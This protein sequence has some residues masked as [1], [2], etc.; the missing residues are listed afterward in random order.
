MYR[1]KHAADAT[2]PDKRFLVLLAVAMP[3][4]FEVDVMCLSQPPAVI[5]TVRCLPALSLSL[6]CSLSAS[7]LVCIFVRSLQ[8]AIYG[9]VWDALEVKARR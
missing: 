5:L 7:N 8:K 1:T 3:C 4:S 2:A 9:E 6:A